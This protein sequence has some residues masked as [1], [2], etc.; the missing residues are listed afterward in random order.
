M[1]KT[2]KHR[3]EKAKEISFMFRKKQRSA[4]FTLATG[5]VRSILRVPTIFIY[6]I[7]GHK[8]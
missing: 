5:E 3:I 4:D 2:I 7:S 8:C 1:F 6:G